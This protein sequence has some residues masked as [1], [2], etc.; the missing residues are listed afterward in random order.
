MCREARSVERRSKYQTLSHSARLRQNLR[1]LYGISFEE[2][3][4]LR[5][6]QDY[7]CAICNVHED[8]SWVG[9]RPPIEGSRLSPNRLHVDHDHLT[10][11]VRGL[12]CARCNIMIGY[13]EQ[14]RERRARIE[15]YLDAP[16]ASLLTA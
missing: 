12:L 4:R 5:T 11:A 16:P 9:G 15:A 2:Y 6:A 3:D 7:R 10:L 8:D 14:S 1:G 13:I